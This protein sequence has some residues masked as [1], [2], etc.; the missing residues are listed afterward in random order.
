MRILVIGATGTIGREVVKAL[1]GQHEVIGASRSGS[2]VD[3]DI[4]DPEAIR[5]MYE[6]VGRVD[7]VVSAAGSGAWKPLEQLDDADFE[8]SLHYK[9]MGQVNVVRYGLEHVNDGG[10]ITTTSGVLARVP[11]QG[12]AAISLVNGGLEGFTR[13]AAFEAPRG[14]RINVVS[15]PWVTETLIAM[16]SKDLSHGLPAATVAQAY[17]RSVTGRETGQVIEP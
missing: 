9:L 2:E 17:V 1:A 8:R 10:S 15:P 13:A 7:A 12:G 5:R 16:G 3:V 6:R 4:L 14:I 11:V